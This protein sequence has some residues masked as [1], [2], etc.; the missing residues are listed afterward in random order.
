[1]SKPQLIAGVT[2]SMLI[3]GGLSGWLLAKNT[4]TPSVTSIATSNSPAGKDYPTPYPIQPPSGVAPADSAAPM[5]PAASSTS[6]S[7]SSVAPAPWNQANIPAG[8]PGNAA[9]GMSPHAQNAG[10]NSISPD[11]FQRRLAAMTANGRT[12]SPRELDALLADMQRSQGSNE[13]AGV[14][15]G[16]LR[17]NLRRADQIQ[18]LAKEMEKLVQQPKPDMP[19]VQLLMAQIQQLQSGIKADVSA[20]PKAK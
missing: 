20:K 13:V 7:P 12:P 4:S 16:V 3:V 2:L 1:M 6:P 15:L 14:D 17:E 18:T 10:G 5:A 11:D 9:P 19:R 8:T